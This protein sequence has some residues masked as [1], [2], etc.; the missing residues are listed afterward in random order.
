MIGISRYNYFA[1]T[2]K[3]NLI[4]SQSVLNSFTKRMNIA[5]QEGLQAMRAS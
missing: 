2:I 3:K 4:V 5:C 1:Y